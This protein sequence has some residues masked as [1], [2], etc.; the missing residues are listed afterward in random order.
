[1]VHVAFHSPTAAN[2]DEGV[3]APACKEFRVF[4]GLASGIRPPYSCPS[5]VKTDSIF[6]RLL[7]LFAAN[8]PPSALRRPSSALRPP[9]SALRHPTR[10]R[11]HPWLK[12]D[13]FLA[14]FSVFCAQPSA[15]R[16]PSS[17]PR[18]PSSVLSPPSSVLSPQ[19]S[20]LRPPSSA[21]AA[22]P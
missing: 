12:P 16:P 21:S 15:L 18:P 5:A 10:I 3:A 11:V 8:P 9:S 6:L 14:P 2:R 13:R 7:R 17:A 22:I 1:M 20:V 4:R 19:S